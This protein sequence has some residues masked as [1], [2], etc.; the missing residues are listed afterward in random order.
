MFIKRFAEK[1]L[2][3]WKNRLNRKPLILKGARQVGKTRLIKEFGK[4]HFADIAYFNFDEEPDL[5]AF[6]LTTK[7]VNRIIE[8]LSMIRGE[9]IRKHETLLVFD[10][11]QEC[12]DAINFLKYIAEN[13]P[14]F[15]VIAA[16][17]LLGVSMGKMN[18][19]PVG[20]VEFLDLY[21]IQFA[22]YLFSYQPNL[23]EYI[24]QLSGEEPIPALFFNQI[25]EQFVV[26]TQF[27]GMPEVL[28]HYVAQMNAAESEMILKNL[29]LSYNY[30]FSKHAEIKDVPRIH[31]IW[32]SLP[33]QLAKENKKFMYQHIKEGA[34]ARDYEDAI[35]W[36]V[37]SGLV[38]KIHLNK[39]PRLPI[40]A[41][42]DLS[43]FKLYGL[44]IGIIRSLAHLPR[45]SF[46][47]LHQLFVEFKGSLAENYVLQSLL[48]QGFDLPRYWS[49]SGKAEVDFIIQHKT[50]II[51]IEVKSGSNVK[52]K[53]LMEYEKAYN[54]SRMIRFSALNIQ[55]QGKLV[56]LPIFLAD[57]VLKWV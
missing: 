39:T 35:N 49:S 37:R 45:L 13:A 9:P 54:P 16:G 56:N 3:T 42:D 15:A 23:Y 31:L 48:A 7:D 34:R 36:L 44:D 55:R 5:K 27:G 21:P 8:Q 1:E 50:E 47:E 2:L 11:I 29:L 4:T 57:W 30:D 25:R 19:F 41:Y 18:S 53:S 33:S 24:E 40:S 26:F 6:F 17:S 38:Y 46:I 22:E 14:E 20:K 52:A 32:E 10:E 43:A 12:V 28:Q 51:P